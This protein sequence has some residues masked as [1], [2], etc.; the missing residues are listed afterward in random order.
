M[1]SDIKALFSKSSYDPLAWAAS[2]WGDRLRLYSEYKEKV[3]AIILKEWE[4]RW[5]NWTDWT[6]WTGQVPLPP[7]IAWSEHQTPITGKWA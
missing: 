1:I 2:P 5:T 6:K 3:K 4:A 7:I